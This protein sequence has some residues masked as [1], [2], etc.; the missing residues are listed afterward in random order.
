MKNLQVQNRKKYHRRIHKKKKESKT[1]TIK[2]I[3]NMTRI[4]SMIR[5][6]SNIMRIMI[7]D[8]RITMIQM[9]GMVNSTIK[10][11]ISK[12]IIKMK[13]M[14]ITTTRITITTITII[15]NMTNR[16]K[17]NN[18]TKINNINIIRTMLI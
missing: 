2:I 1:I 10:T 9:L 12:T 16:T 11:M 8:K 7:T 15:S 3:S 6:S 13:H 4:N 14:I 18:N 17:S 5:I